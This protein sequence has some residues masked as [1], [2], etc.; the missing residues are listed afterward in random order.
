MRQRLASSYSRRYVGAPSSDPSGP[1]RPDSV[2]ML[3]FR[4]SPTA[5]TRDR[6]WVHQRDCPVSRRSILA[7]VFGA[8]RRTRVSRPCFLQERLAQPPV[9]SLVALPPTGLAQV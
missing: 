6:D 5:L 3:S 9:G 2:R 8:R 1:R 4:P 7:L